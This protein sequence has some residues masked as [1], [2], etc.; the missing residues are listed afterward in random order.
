MTFFKK[1]G[2]P[3]IRKRARRSSGSMPGRGRKRALLLRRDGPECWY[4]ACDMPEDDMTIEHLINRS[5]G[6]SNHVDNLVLAHGLCNR[7]AANR[8]LR[9]KDELRLRLRARTAR[10][11]I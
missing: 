1:D 3:F 5:D 4:C 8:T 9:E 11:L 10:T 2:T 6:G 7:R